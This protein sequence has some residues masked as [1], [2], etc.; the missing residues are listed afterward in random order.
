MR[1]NFIVVISLFV[2]ASCSG[3]EDNPFNRPPEIISILA[4]SFVSAND[5]IFVTAY[6]HENDTLTL[7]VTVLTAEENTVG[8]AFSKL[9]TDDG[10]A[11]DHAANDRIFTGII[12]RS[13]LQ[14]QNTSLFSFVF[15]VFEKGRNN[16]TSQTITISQNPA[17]G[18]PPTVDN[19]IA[20][21]T[22]NTTLQTEFTVTIHASDPEGLSDI[23][24]VTMKSPGNNFFGLYDNGVNPDVSANDGI[25]SGGFS[26]IPP[27]AE[28]NYIFT[29]QA[30]DRLG[31][32]SNAIQ[33]A[34]VI[35]H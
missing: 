13:A 17:N 26:V 9:F 23:Q 18:H 19:L 32:K 6:D 27:P 3:D 15:T 1:P 10:L 2:F 25:F 7:K 12:N 20:P 14:A 31:L 5:T 24:S 35:V 22:V 4:P 33:K 16:G 30:T 28:G 34:I 8:S 29:F 21:D 11:G